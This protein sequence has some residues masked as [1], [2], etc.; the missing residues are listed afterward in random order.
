MTGWPRTARWRRANRG[1]PEAGRHLLGWA[2][3]AGYRDVQASA[4][5]WCFATPDERAWW[6]GLWAD[7]MRV[8]SVAV[9]A[10]D[11][12]HATRAQLD[13]M[14]D[15]FEAWSRHP[16]AWFAVLHGEILAH[17]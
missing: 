2:H 17:P 9:Q 15:A 12:G 8:S 1:E 7:R 4:S 11:G 13:A 10:M 14:A 3:G 6:G 5:V 16:D